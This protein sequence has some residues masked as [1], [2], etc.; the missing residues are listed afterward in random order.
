MKIVPS[1]MK[2]TV[3]EMT[4]EF[5]QELLDKNHPNNRRPKGGRISQYRH[6]ML[7]GNWQLTHQAVALDEDGF[8]V[9]GQ[10]RLSAVV[11]AGVPV[12]MAFVT[13]VPS[14]AIIGADCGTV[15]NVADAARITGN[16]FAH[17]ETHYGAVARRMALGLQKQKNSL[18]IPETLQFIATHRRAIEFS[19]EVF[20]LKKKKGITQSAVLAVVARSYY[21]RGCRDRIKEFGQ[22]MLSGL[23]NDRHRDSAAIRLRNWLMES[24][25]G[26]RRRTKGLQ[27]P[28]IMIYAKCEIGL[29]HFIEG[30]EITTLKSTS[31][32]LFPIPADPQESNGDESV[33]KL[34]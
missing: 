16:P 5:A 2:F 25:T 12:P 9:D 31:E 29:H 26:G 8:L 10:N 7:A 22:V 32:E 27:I 33:L 15:R 20:E 11:Q 14:R 21:R 17:G 19:F 30:N 3:V 18:S 13:G 4:P 23:P 1:K 28:Q 6:D 24:T 34:A